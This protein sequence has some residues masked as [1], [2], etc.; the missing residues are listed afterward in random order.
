MWKLNQVTSVCGRLNN[1]Q[2]FY[3]QQFKPCCG[4]RWGPGPYN[5]L[6]FSFSPNSNCLFSHLNP[7]LHPAQLVQEVRVLGEEN[8]PPKSMV[9]TTKRLMLNIPTTTP[10]LAKRKL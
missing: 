10:R 4:W 6:I 8:S 3:F 1:L 5:L 7:G 2:T 9:R